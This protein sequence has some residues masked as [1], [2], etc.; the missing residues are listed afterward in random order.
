MPIRNKEH[1]KYK[2][3]GNVSQEYNEKFVNALLKYNKCAE[4]TLSMVLFP[5]IIEKCKKILLEF[6]I[7]MAW[8]W[9]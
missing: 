1:I 5:V 8:S 3:I 6:F 4:I 9:G 2:A 7:P